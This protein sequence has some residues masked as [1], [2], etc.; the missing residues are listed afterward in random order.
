MARHGLKPIVDQT[1]MQESPAQVRGA[2]KEL[3]P[4]IPD[5]DLEDIVTRA[6]QEGSHRV[7]TNAMLELPRR[8]Q[9]ATI[10]R[11][12]HTYTDYDQLL[13][14]FGWAQARQ[15][16]EQDC[17]QKLIEWRGEND[18]EDDNELEEIV[19]ETIVIDDDEEGIEYGSE[20]D[21]EDSDAEISDAS[22]A[23]I[24]V[25][26]EL[27]PED[28]LGAES[29]FENSRQHRVDRRND[30]VRQR[31]GAVRQQMRNGFPPPPT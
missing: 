25:L 12:R 29:S 16:S 15:D 8:V 10:A 24:E 13:R 26:H 20:A 21:D 19:R 7:G 3:F 2:I 27:A 14:A 18:N 28:D 11:I 31:I 1:A 17:L 22:D 4:R 6:W 9:L 5:E 30:D 23:S